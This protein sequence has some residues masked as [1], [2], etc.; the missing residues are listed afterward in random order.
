M[1][2]IKSYSLDVTIEA[3]EECVFERFKELCGF[4]EGTEVDRDRLREAVLCFWEYLSLLQVRAVYS[5]FDANVFADNNI[6]IDKRVFSEIL[7]SNVF[8]IVFFAVSVD[9]GVYNVKNSFLGNILKEFYFDLTCNAVIDISRKILKNIFEDFDFIK[10][11]AFFVSRAFG[12]GFFGIGP[13]EI[14]Y[15]F[16]LIDCSKIG[17]YLNESGV[18]YPEKS[19]V[20]FF[21]VSENKIFIENDCES[22][23]GTKDG[24]FF[25]GKRGF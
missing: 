23:V 11:S 13:E 10:N 24:C 12:P 9:T 17:I 4:F 8:K 21:V 14:S 2:E 1:I 6:Y 20:G 7:K 16:K 19:F 5:F 15:F 18:I 25:C 22:C 3:Y